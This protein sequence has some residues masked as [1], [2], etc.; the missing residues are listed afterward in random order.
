MTFIYAIFRKFSVN[1]A[2]D[3]NVLSVECSSRERKEEILKIY[4]PPASLRKPTKIEIELGRSFWK[5]CMLAIEPS[6]HFAAEPWTVS[7]CVKVARASQSLGT[8]QA[9]A[10]SAYSP[11]K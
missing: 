11:Y 7:V 3:L 6:P 10:L 1:S 8:F 5:S 2:I 4:L 9:A